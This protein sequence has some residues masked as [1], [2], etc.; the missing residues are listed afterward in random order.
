MPLSAD[1]RALLGLLLERDQSYA[2]IS[3]LLGI[4]R[5]EVR[6]RARAA[7]AAL[8]VEDPDRNVG[9]TDYLLGQA[10]PIG[11]ADAV[12]HLREDPADRALAERVLASLV[13]LAPGAE[14]PRL[15]GEAR[16]APHLRAPG[17]RR[18][19]DAPGTAGAEQ[20][21]SAL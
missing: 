4:S 14:L 21:A 13:E 15:P 3:G 12:R 11:R 17:L 8:G 1:Q 18:R 6:F 20:P 10:D 5:D 16:T 9:L 19:Q 2:D 7:L